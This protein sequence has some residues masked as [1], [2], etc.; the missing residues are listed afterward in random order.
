MITKESLKE[1]TKEKLSDW[2]ASLGHLNVQL[3]LGK[4]EARDEFEKQKKNLADWIDTAGE[5][6][7]NAKHISKEKALQLKAAIEE[8]RV[9]AALG[10]AET[11]D[12]LNKQ[13]ENL[14]KG[15]HNLKYKIAETYKTTKEEI[16]DFTDKAHDKLEDFHTR[17]DLFK[18][19]AHL[20][21]MDAGETWDKKKKEL[22]V[23]LHNLNT[24]LEESKEVSSE[25]WVKFSEEMSEAW[26]HFRNAFT[27]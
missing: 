26:S 10:R 7:H 12:A 20:A 13:Q 19:H 5:K 16:D 2:K 23:K 25:K 6:L 27:I 22:S 24:K 11:E 15:I 9:Q 8:L 14:N 21:K 3:H 4:K 17:F 1:K 18:I